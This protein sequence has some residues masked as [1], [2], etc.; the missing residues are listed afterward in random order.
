ME[1]VKITGT[2]LDVARRPLMGYVIFEAYP[3]YIIE[4]DQK[5]F[6]AGRY[7]ATLDKSGYMEADLVASVGW[8]YKVDFNLY[9]TEGT[10]V[11]AEN[12][13]VSIPSGGP[14]PKF[15]SLNVDPATR[16]P[17]I[18]LPSSEYPDELVPNHFALD[19]ND[20]GSILIS[21]AG[22]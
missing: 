6:V 20:P 10:L 9:N 5:T 15:L 8:A 19:P 18:S 17:V 1:T 3:Q 11:Y 13:I 21:I 14:L 2:F 16:A 7:T 22:A 12:T 4:D